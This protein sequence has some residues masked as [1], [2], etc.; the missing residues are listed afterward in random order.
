MGF[1]DQL[2]S[3][4]DRARAAFM[5]IPVLQRALRGDIAND[6]YQA[7]LGQA[8][9]HVKHTVPLMMACGTRLGEERQWLL[10]AMG[11]YIEEEMGH[12]HW[13]LD[14]IRVCGGDPDAVRLAAPHPATELMVAY[15][16]DVVQ[17]RNPVGLFGMVFVLE[18]TSVRLATQAAEAIQQRLHLPVSAF[19]Y[20]T[21]HGALDRNHLAFFERLMNRV[22]E[23]AD[24]AMIRHCANMFY[25]LYGDIFRSLSS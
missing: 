5:H 7:F 4:T 8:Y 20:L 3:D 2:I 10:R 6:E 14:D 16:Y 1:F 21:S 25:R 18:D 9:H 13:I 17:R 15:A 12:E 23:P 19:H 24:Q 22:E 11:R